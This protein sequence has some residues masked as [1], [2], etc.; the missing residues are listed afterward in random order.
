MDLLPDMKRSGLRMLRECRER[1]PHQR[2]LAIPTCITTR[3]C[4]T[5][6]D[7]YR[8]YKPAVSFEVGG[9]ENVPGIPAHAQPANLC[10]W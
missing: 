7:A 5:Y 6:R 9:G 4:R 1:F 2:G 8:D 10:I 3:A